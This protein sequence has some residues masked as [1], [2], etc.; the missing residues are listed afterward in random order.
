MADVKTHD[1]EPSVSLLFLRDEGLREG[2]ELLYF[3]YRDFTAEA[4]EILKEPGFGRA[5]HRALHFIARN[6]GIRITELLA[7]LKITKQSLGRVLKDLIAAGMVS[8][9]QGATDKREKHLAL[10]E[11]G[12]ALEK[13]L[14]A[15]LKRAIAS[16]YRSAGPEAVQGFRDVLLGLMKDDTRK[17]IDTMAK[18]RR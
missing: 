12:T 15:T 9:T 3:A 1:R 14:S 10:T 6:P 16:A 18:K 17:I 8:R 7:V 4:D 5:H 11:K 2:M 13:R